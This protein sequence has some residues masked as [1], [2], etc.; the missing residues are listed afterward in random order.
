MTTITMQLIT[1][2]SPSLLFKLLPVGIT[3][4]AFN[5]S[6]TAQTIT[7]SSHENAHLAQLAATP[8]QLDPQLE[9]QLD[10]LIDGELV[11]SDHAALDELLRHI[12]AN[13]PID[14]FVRAHGY[15]VMRLAYAKEASAALALA[16]ELKIMATTAKSQDALGEVETLYGEIYLATE[17]LPLALQQVEQLKDR[18][19]FT[20][21]ARIRYHMNHFI[22]RALQQSGNY[23]EALQYLLT[24]R[25][26]VPQ[27]Q[28]QGQARRRLF[29]NVLLARIQAHLGQWQAAEETARLAIQ[30]AISQDFTEDLPDLYLL[31]AYAQQYQ[32]GPSPALVEAFLQTAMVAHE[33][34][35]GRV[36]ML[37]YNNAGA[38][39]LLLNNLA[40]ATKH[41]EQG[42]R[43]A[44][45]LD[46]PLER[47][48]TEFNLGYIKVL[49]GQHQQG[50]EAML[51]AAE[52]FNQL[53]QKRERMLLLTH[54]A[55]A[56]SVMGDYQNQ[57]DTLAQQLQLTQ[58]LAEEERSKQVAEL[59]LRFD[60]AE[61]S[62]QIKLLEQQAEIRDQELAAQQRQQLGTQAAA[63]FAF[64][65]LAI[66]AFGYRKTRRLN[67]LLHHANTEL[68]HQSLHD[69][70]T[71]LYNRRALS[72][73][74]IAAD[75]YL[76]EAP[77]AV[78][79]I[80]I[81]HFKAINDKHGHAVGDEVLIA[82]AQRLRNSIRATDTTIRWGGEEFLVL[83]KDIDQQSLL[84]V[85][86][87]VL[88]KVVQAPFATSAGRLPISISAG[89]ALVTQ[90]EV[91]SDLAD[92]VKQADTLL[93]Q[94][95]HAGRTRLHYALTPTR[96]ES[97]SLQF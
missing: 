95:K 71:G 2:R 85:V 67:H 39:E 64:V 52:E 35:N 79:I 22:V 75:P 56:Y 76:Q 55:K 38:A 60:A 17:Q 57:A 10:K 40:E 7:F 50:I 6:A 73:S 23:P 20:Q 63:F 84:T 43:L 34:N 97:I 28:A 62:Y 70:L 27:T 61:K 11:P 1:L 44:K 58:E 24:A 88:Q 93:Y 14:T 37:G 42:L 3:L 82:F 29:L 83:F 86:Q 5:H 26:L 92:A 80:D 30:Q 78:L 31:H 12:N 15:Q 69:P 54:I 32:T 74:R 66:V 36:E 65:F 72:E 9:R 19:P 59:Q 41:L 90:H 16:A 91:N 87:S 18:L 8:P 51:T 77:Y 94:A 47:T 89:C 21:S 53:A 68:Q 46:R 81:D 49:Q 25:E 33:A 96:V 13:T 48:V 45:Q 4:L